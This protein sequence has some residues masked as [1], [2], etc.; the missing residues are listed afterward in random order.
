MEEAKLKSGARNGDLGSD[1]TRDVRG[2]VLIIEIA[3]REYLEIGLIAKVVT[4]TIACPA[5][6][7][8]PPTAKIA[9]GS[10]VTGSLVT[11]VEIAHGLEGR[12]L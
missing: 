9:S 7:A 4:I 6:I 3:K 11:E 2:E 12:C 1:L 8:C 5:S 10:I